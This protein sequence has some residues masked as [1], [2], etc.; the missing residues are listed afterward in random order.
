[1]RAHINTTIEQLSTE[2]VQQSLAE[3]IIGFVVGYATASLLIAMLSAFLAWWLA[4]LLALIAATGIA[5]LP[6][7]QQGVTLSA[8]ATVKH[9]RA[10][11]AWLNTK[12]QSSKA[13]KA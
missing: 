8:T 9:G 11:F 4:A 3:I 6:I 2:A 10:A 13:V 7:V 12:L 1:M 5:M